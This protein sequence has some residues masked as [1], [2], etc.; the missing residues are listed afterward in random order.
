MD[1]SVYIILSLNHHLPNLAEYIAFLLA[2]TI[3][4]VNV[5]F[6]PPCTFK[7]AYLK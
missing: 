3:N 2:K 5:L 1:N 6:F 7:A 4:L